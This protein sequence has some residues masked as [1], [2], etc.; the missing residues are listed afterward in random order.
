M[1]AMV[2]QIF[3]IRH[4]ETEWSANGRHTGATDLPL[5][6]DGERRAG[7]LRE[8]LRGIRFSQVLTSPL[9]RARRTCELAGLDGMARVE[10]GL[11]EWNY[12]QYEGRTTAEIRAGRPGWNLFRDGCPQGE[13][14]EEVS[15]RADG[16]LAGV[17]PMAGAV[18]LFSHGHFL[19][20]LSARWIGLP[21]SD[22]AHLLIG[23]ASR[24]IL[25]F[26]HPGGGNPVIILLN[27]GPDS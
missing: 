23:T 10:P 22:G 25:G 18:A 1:H 14:V 5:N 16:I 15:R 6:A 7:L 17:R 19:R 24:S 2:E 26:E 8:A 11:H 21:G 13:S 20:V 12:G 3:L 27:A 9:R 4:G